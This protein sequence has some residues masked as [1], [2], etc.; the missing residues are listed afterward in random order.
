MGYS[1]NL[2]IYLETVGGVSKAVHRFQLRFLETEGVAAPRRHA[3]PG[4]RVAST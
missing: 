3:A 4:Y 2:E 1:R